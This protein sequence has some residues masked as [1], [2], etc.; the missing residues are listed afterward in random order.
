MKMTG[1]LLSVCLGTALV[2]CSPKPQRAIIGKWQ[3]IP[4]STPLLTRVEVSGPGAMTFDFRPEGVLIT[5][6][7]A[8]VSATG[9]DGKTEKQGGNVPV[10]NRYAFVDDHTLKIAFAE[11]LRFGGREATFRI[12]ASHNQLVLVEKEPS[13]PSERDGGAVRLQRIR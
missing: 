10:T 7:G 4:G 3:Q 1:I 8:Q 12:S 6:G 9:I 2:A 13:G 11:G 5:Q